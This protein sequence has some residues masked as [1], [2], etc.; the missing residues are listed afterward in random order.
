T[1]P[2]GLKCKRRKFIQLVKLADTL[3]NKPKAIDDA[4]DSIKLG[5]VSTENSPGVTMPIEKSQQEIVAG[6]MERNSQL[7]ASLDE[8][9]IK[10]N[11][12]ES[13]WLE[14]QN[15]ETVTTIE[16]NKEK[17]TVEET[18]D[19]SQTLNKLVEAMTT[20][21]TKME[22]MDKEMKRL[23][24]ERAPSNSVRQSTTATAPAPTQN[25]S[26]T[27]PAPAP[28]HNATDNNTD[29]ATLM[30][31][32]IASLFSADDQATAGVLST[33]EEGKRLGKQLRSGHD[34]TA[35]SK[36]LRQ[37]PWPHMAIHRYPNIKGPP[38]E[39]LSK[40][41]FFHGFNLQ[42]KDPEWIE[43]KVHLEKILDGLLEDCADYP[44]DW[45]SI[46][47]F[48]AIVLKRIERKRL[49]WEDTNEISRLRQKYIYAAYSLKKNQTSSSAGELCADY[50]KGTC[51]QKR[52]HDGR[53][54]LCA[55]CNGT[56]GASA[57]HPKSACF[58]LNGYPPRAQQDSKQQ[59][60][61]TK[62]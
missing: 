4:D 54:H 31:R 16:K 44:H 9:T 34:M 35:E 61:G 42:L 36:V 7:I 48:Y 60:L 12:L 24:A 28:T 47:S 27:A 17:S 11:K 10:H 8:L 52:D 39:T 37:V 3:G 43:L 40:S 15:K 26:T 51:P 13:K 20:L 58:K 22:N 53:L 50:N 23:G 38:Y 49:E 56:P 19:Q 45:P 32:K 5:D 1:A 55:H 57:R 46:R 62:S 21:T 18:P 25:A 30:L 33:E 41:E 59:T 2:T 14:S 29:A 6:L